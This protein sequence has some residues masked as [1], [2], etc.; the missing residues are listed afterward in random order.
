MHLIARWACDK[1][2]Q[3]LGRPTASDR[4]GDLASQTA[5]HHFQAGEGRVGINDTRGDGWCYQ[6][7]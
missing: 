5:R 1:L 2:E 6:D 7:Q 4:R 3:E